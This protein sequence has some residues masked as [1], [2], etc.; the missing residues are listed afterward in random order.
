MISRPKNIHNIIY[1]KT[2]KEMYTFGEIIGH[3]RNFSGE[4]KVKYRPQAFKKNA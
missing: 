4:K 2:G 1:N 3:K